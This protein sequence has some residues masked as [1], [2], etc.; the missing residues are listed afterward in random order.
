[1]T[2]VDAPPA[3][4]R[5]GDAVDVL[6][7]EPSLEGI[8]LPAHV[9]S[10]E[11][12]QLECEYSLA[13]HAA[14]APIRAWAPRTQVR[15]APRDDT[16]ESKRAHCPPLAARMDEVHIAGRVFGRRFDVRLRGDDARRH[17]RADVTAPA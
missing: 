11:E 12:N 17:A 9:V 14:L 1:M 8:W 13:E 16:R 6:Q 10:M 3:S 7:W 4:A 5:V 2:R 15:L